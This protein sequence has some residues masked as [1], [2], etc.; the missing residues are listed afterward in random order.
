VLIIM[1]MLGL[2]YA[3]RPLRPDESVVVAVFV[4]DAAWTRDGSVGLSAGPGLEVA[5]PA[6]RIPGRREV[7]WRVRA[8]EAGTHLLTV[9]TPRGEV[10]KRIEVREN[11]GPLV[12]LAAARGRAFS[13]AFLEYPAEPPIPGGAGVR[14]IRV[15]DWP[16]RE[17]R[18][19]GLAVNWLVAFFVLSLVAGFAVK[20]AFGVEV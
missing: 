17:L 7:N 2:R 3:H 18:F 20:D 6:L 14:E 13:G 9:E 12:A 10:T 16:E 8:R 1:A 11:P 4:D 19:L 5:S 15:V